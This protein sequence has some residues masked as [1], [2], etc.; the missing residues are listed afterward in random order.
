MTIYIFFYPD[1]IIL[2][3]QRSCDTLVHGLSHNGFLSILLN[4]CSLNMEWRRFIYR[5]Q[6]STAGI[7]TQS[8]SFFIRCF[9]ANQIT[10]S[11]HENDSFKNAHHII[12][13]VLDLWFWCS[14][15]RDTKLSMT[16][17]WFVYDFQ[18]NNSWNTV[19][20]YTFYWFLIWE[21]A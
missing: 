18:R 21:R 8:W 3:I 13:P 14:Q 16:S 4:K 12:N 5:F 19:R 2:C 17:T 1:E 7:K 9:N 11:H 6:R 15:I 20:V 10:G